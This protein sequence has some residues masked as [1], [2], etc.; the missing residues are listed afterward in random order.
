MTRAYF[1]QYS[2]R[3][4]EMNL[5]R[6]VAKL[7]HMAE[8]LNIEPG[9]M[10]LDVGTGTG[11]LIPM[12]FRNSGQIVALDFAE[13]ML[14]RARAKGFNGNIDYL[15]AD[16]TNIPLCDSIFDVTVCYS[17]FPHFHD[18]PRALA[19]I[20]RVT[21][22]GGKLFI[23]HTSSRAK[24]N[25][26]H[27]QVPALVDDLIP[28]EEEMQMMLSKAGFINIVIEDNSESYLASAEKAEQEWLREV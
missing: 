20:K 16:V 7:E 13:E 21:R 28:D 5:E 4:D 24:I 14:R 26:I 10:V 18:K 3:W 25:E 19:E 23:C 22:S 27:R 6:D 15:I 2:A 1:N 11:V 8:Q 9:A 12:L 17:S